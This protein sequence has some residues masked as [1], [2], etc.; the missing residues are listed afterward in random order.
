MT[1]L[2]QSSDNL[3]IINIVMWNQ[4][5]SWNKKQKSNLL[6]NKFR[7]YLACVRVMHLYLHQ[8]LC[9]WCGYKLTMILTLQSILNNL[10]MNFWFESVYLD[11]KFGNP[12]AI[13]IS[14]WTIIIR[15]LPICTG[16]RDSSLNTKHRKTFT[17]I[18]VLTCHTQCITTC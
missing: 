9:Y 7:E 2:N 6:N 18:S 17:K 1:I 10:V 16:T 13:S 5:Q 12:L 3:P 11:C 14:Q 8:V 4:L 15:L